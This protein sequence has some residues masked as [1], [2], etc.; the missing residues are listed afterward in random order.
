MVYIH[1]I[2]TLSIAQASASHTCIVSV[3]RPD[4]IYIITTLHI[5]VIH[6]LVPAQLAASYREVFVE[7]EPE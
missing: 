4:I 3:F 6:I 1:S 2:A 5:K 7:V